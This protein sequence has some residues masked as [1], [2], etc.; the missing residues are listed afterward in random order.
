MMMMRL[1]MNNVIMVHNKPEADG[2]TVV[3]VQCVKEQFLHVLSLPGVD[4]DYCDRDHDDHD[5]D[6]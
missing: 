3:C 1:L 2:P 6:V 4:H 5:C